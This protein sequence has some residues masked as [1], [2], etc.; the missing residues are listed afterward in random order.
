MGLI[1][2]PYANMD[3]SSKRNRWAYVLQ[4]SSRRG[5]L[6]HHPNLQ[7]LSPVLARQQAHIPSNLPSRTKVAQ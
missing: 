6:L 3:L 7:Y 4:N 2:D 5:F 1:P